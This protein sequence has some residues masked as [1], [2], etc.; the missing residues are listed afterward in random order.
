VLQIRGLEDH[1]ALSAATS[2]VLAAHFRQ[3]S[4]TELHGTVLV[5]YEKVGP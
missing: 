4:A 5:L 2:T 1:N 3:I